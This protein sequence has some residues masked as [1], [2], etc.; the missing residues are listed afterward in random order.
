M[1]A[2][3]L[4]AAG[5][6]DG[7]SAPADTRSRTALIDDRLHRNAV[8]AE[9][10]RTLEPFLAATGLTPRFSNEGPDYCGGGAADEPGPTR[11]R[12][13]IHTRADWPVGELG[14]TEKVQAMVDDLVARGWRF[15]GTSY[16]VDDVVRPEDSWNIVMAKGVADIRV[17]ISTDQPIV[18][19]SLHSEC[20][21]VD[22]EPQ[23]DQRDVHLAGEIALTDQA[24]LGPDGEL[25]PAREP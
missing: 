2:V 4:I 7:S 13:N 8:R 9:V 3:L 25:L 22:K 24:T 21:D 14:T 17:G 16:S 6:N 20:T 5:C 11:Y 10:S 18:L 23:T 12:Y 1:L 19:I 15:D